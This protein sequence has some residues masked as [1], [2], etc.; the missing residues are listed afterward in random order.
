MGVSHSFKEV[1]DKFR[2]SSNNVQSGVRPALNEAAA[3]AEVT[4]LQSAT[5]ARTKGITIRKFSSASGSTQRVAVV[6]G[7]NPGWV[8]IQNDGTQPHFIGPH[9]RG[10]QS[11]R[12]Q[13]LT[14]GFGRKSTRAGALLLSALGSAFG[15]PQTVSGGKGAINIKGIG[16]KAYALHPGTRGKKFAGRGIKAAEPKV[17]ATYNKVQFSNMAKPFV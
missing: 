11:L 8:H 1:A 17:V 6:Y 4:M 15:A 3:I 16:V 7:P 10:K 13:N 14:G 5:A 2:A 9:G 12:R